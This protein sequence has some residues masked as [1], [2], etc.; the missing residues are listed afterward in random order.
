M[1][2]FVSLLII[3][4]GLTALAAPAWSEEKPVD[5]YVI[6]NTNA[7]AIPF[8]GPQMLA[9]FHGQAG[10]ARIVDD[11]VARAVTDRRLEEILHATDLERLRRTLKEQIDYL[12]A[13]G[14]DYSG[15]DM[16]TAHKDQGINTAEFNALVEILQLAMDK[17]GVAFRAQNQLL[18][19]LAPMKRDV[20]TR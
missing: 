10:V 12:L 17:E 16:K 18:A 19:K 11:L 3:T 8:S 9:A 13:A 14:V 20:V 7:G 4:S 5:P 15:R 2:K 1:R 6:S